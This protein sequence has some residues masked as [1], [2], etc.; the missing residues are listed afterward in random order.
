MDTKH[1]WRDLRIAY[2]ISTIEKLIEE[3]IHAIRE[4]AQATLEKPLL[5][6]SLTLKRQSRPS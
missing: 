3:P 1:R 4:E 2:A 5:N 6:I